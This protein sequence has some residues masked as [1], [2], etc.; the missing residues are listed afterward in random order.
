[1]AKKNL[2]FQEEKGFV[3]CKRKIGIKMRTHIIR[4]SSS[5]GG[6]TVSRKGS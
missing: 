2:L 6:N 4:G 3:C 1:M 5:C